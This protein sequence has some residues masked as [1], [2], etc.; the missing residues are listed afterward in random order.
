MKKIILSTVVSLLSLLNLHKRKKKHS[1]SIEKSSVE[2]IGEKVTGTH[3][4][5]ISLKDGYFK[6][7][8]NKLV[9]GE[10]NIDMNSITCTDIENKEYAAKL[11]DHLKNDD[12][13]ATDK[14]PLIKF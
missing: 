8:D 14:H 2:W 1:I 6:F 7:E 12:F 13:F 4:G 10:F 11:V 5:L 3:S 9:G